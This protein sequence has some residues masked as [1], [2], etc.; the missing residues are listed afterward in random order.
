VREGVA[1]TIDILP[2][3]GRDGGQHRQSLV[4]IL[5]PLFRQGLRVFRNVDLSGSTFGV[6]HGEAVR[7]ARRRPRPSWSQKT[8]WRQGFFTTEKS[9]SRIS[10]SGFATGSDRIAYESN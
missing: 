9:N 8:D 10:P 1:R 4:I 5:H 3:V 6:T 2:Q 7:G